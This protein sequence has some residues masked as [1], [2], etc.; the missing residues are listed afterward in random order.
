MD[1]PIIESA[2]LILRPVSL[3][4]LER[5]HAIWTEP[6]VRRYLWDDEIINI[7]TAEEVIRGSIESFENNGFGIWGV[8]SKE[9]QNL[10]GFC[11]YRYIDKSS[12]IEI[13]YGLE[14]KFWGKGITTEAA[15]AILRYGFKEIKFEVIEG[16]T[17]IENRASWKV[18]EKIGMKFERRD[19]SNN[20]DLLFYSISKSVPRNLVQSKI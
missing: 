5:M 19:N 8:Y 9:R 20:Q 10:I 3:D 4:D 15:K 1:H 16:I 11:G 14:P 6:D 18:L 2:R 7:E 12:R 17:N 13:I